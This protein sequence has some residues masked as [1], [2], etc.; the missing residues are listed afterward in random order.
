MGRYIGAT[1]RLCRREGV[2]L[3]LKGIRCDTPKCALERRGDKSP[4]MQGER[5]RKLSDY[6]V[7]LREKQKLKR[8]Y[9]MRENQFQRLFKEASRKKGVT[10]EVFLTL[11][12]RRLD[13]VIYRMGMASSRK[14]AR[15]LVTHGFFLVNGKAINIPSYLTKEGDV[16]EVKRNK[17]DKIK[18]MLER[19]PERSIPAWLEVNKEELAGK[20]L[21]FPLRG[22]IDVPVEE[23]MVVELYS[24]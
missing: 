15:Q 1:C 6:G 4:G 18:N 22:E 3:Y 7:R 5:F 10:G 20:V 19:V 14:E 9:G 13:N 12:E 23:Q 11:L 16:I 24:R 2:K 8:I 17:Q 21:R